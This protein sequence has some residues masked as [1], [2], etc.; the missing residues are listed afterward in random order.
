MQWTWLLITPLTVIL[1]NC[2]G[3]VAGLAK[4]VNNKNPEWGKQLTPITT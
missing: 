1:I 4:A 3:I 2:F